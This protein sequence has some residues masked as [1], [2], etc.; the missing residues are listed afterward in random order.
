MTRRANVLA[1][2]IL[3]IGRIDRTEQSVVQMQKDLEQMLR[4]AML[5]GDITMPRPTII[6]P[7]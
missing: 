3:L 2:M 7:S 6:S 5:N 4:R 1:S